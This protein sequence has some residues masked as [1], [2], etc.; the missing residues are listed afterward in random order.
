MK[1]LTIVFIV[2]FLGL[3]SSC[4]KKTH[5]GKKVVFDALMDLDDLYSL[6]L[7]SETSSDSLLGVTVS[8]TEYFYFQDAP[9][10]A[11]GILTMAGHSQTPVSKYLTTAFCKGREHPRY[12]KQIEEKIK[13]FSL[14]KPK[15]PP[16]P[17]TGVQLLKKI[18]KKAH[19]KLTIIA[20]GPLTNIAHAISE[21]PEI[22]EKIE[23]I[24]FLGGSLHTTENVSIPVTE[25]RKFYS[26]YTMLIDPCAAEFILTSGIPLTLIPFDVTSLLPLN[27]YV[28]DRYLK[29]TSSKKAE[30][31]KKVLKTAI[32]KSSDAAQTPFW[33]M[34]AYMCIYKPSLVKLSKFP[35][36]VITEPGENYASL[37]IS[38]EGS[39]VDVCTYIDT[40]GFYDTFFGIING[41]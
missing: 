38:D 29:P 4:T 23:R 10:T 32:D 31:V 2:F 36:Q 18:A 39:P 8:G 6:F 11:A 22:K 17:I 41:L 27:D 9:E 20:V 35:L 40:K 15:N 24:I 33:N 13:Q 14:P 19:G 30:F 28:L 5:P 7:I 16:L 12:Q 26:K 25:L 34:I 3:S 37:I 1:K 21:H